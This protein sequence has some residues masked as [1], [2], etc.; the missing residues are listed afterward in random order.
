VQK[1]LSWRIY[2][3]TVPHTSYFTERQ[4][5]NFTFL[6]NQACTLKVFS[7]QSICVYNQLQSND[8]QLERA[9]QFCSYLTPW[10]SSFRLA[11][12]VN[13]PTDNF[14]RKWASC[15]KWYRAVTQWTHWHLVV[16]AIHV[17]SMGK[18]IRNNVTEPHIDIL[19]WKTEKFYILLRLQ[20]YQQNQRAAQ[21]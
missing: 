16:L 17:T 4:V 15:T 19:Y 13:V 7:H 12:I 1:W 10:L 9:A 20:S 11:I 14:I 21:Y 6:N 3:L 8:T 2:A 5:N 18:M